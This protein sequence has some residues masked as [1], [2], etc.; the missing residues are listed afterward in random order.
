V[1]APTVMAF[2]TSALH[3]TSDSTPVE[4]SDEVLVEICRTLVS[5]AE[6]EPGRAA[7]FEG[8]LLSALSLSDKGGLL[9]KSHAHFDERVRTAVCGALGQ[10]GTGVSLE[11]LTALSEGE[12]PLAEAAMEAVRRIRGEDG[13]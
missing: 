9:R 11:A 3:P 2:F 12:G 10:V 7:E 5:I 4:T 6:A 1:I 8:L 13:D